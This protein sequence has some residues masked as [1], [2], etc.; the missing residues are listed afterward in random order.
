MLDPMTRT[1][2]LHLHREGHG[3]RTI[4]RAVGVSRTTV[5]RVLAQGQAEPPPIVRP[6]LL[7]AHREQI[8]ELF[9]RC[10][11]NRVR[12]HEELR[13]LGVEVAYST[14]TEFCR[15]EQL[16]LPPKK[17]A[18]RY[19]FE[20]GEEMQHDTSPH[21]VAVG[22]RSRPLQ[23]ASVVLAYSRLLYAQCYPTF[24]RFIAKGFLTEALQW[25]GGAARRCLVD[26]TSV[27]VASGTGR[28][29]LIAPEM[30]AFA[31]RFGFAFA[32]HAVGDANR[33]ARVERPFSFIEGN[34]YPGRTFS[35]LADLNVQLRAWCEAK[36]SRRLRELK[37]SP[38]E[39][40]AAEHPHLVAL[41]L[42]VP[43]VYALHNRTVDV[44]GYVCLHT[45]RYSV[46][47][48]LIHRRVE[49]HETQ[50]AVRILSQHRL[51]CTH[52]VA[53]P[54]AYRRCTL[55][56]HQDGRFKKA[57]IVTAAPLPEETTLRAQGA[58]FTALVE[59]LRR[60]HG[61]RAS[62]PLRRLHRLFLDY[63]TAP[64]R[65]TL[66]EALRFGLTDLGRI[67]RMVLRRLHGEFFRLPPAS[68]AQ[69]EQDD[70]DR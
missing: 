13:A 40:F 36:S 56:E 48:A 63:P 35:D 11:G 45:N 33:S 66:A 53:E 39:L 52:P 55:P 62:R 42:H 61:G 2:I 37:A 59:A 16:G 28:N 6:E 29:A 67:E 50:H 21:T 34:F 4:A 32:A 15:R 26:N 41:P 9:G 38:R 10:K 8:R 65:A 1:A 58:E 57:G 3:A 5:K 14:L 19:H 60:L 68:D 18:G 69:H 23:C 24:N 17:R 27:V 31:Q 12:V 22:G 7:A 49:V 43:E 70:D 47:T 25:F 46:P 51:V 20:P 54:G 30:E 44:E 64:L